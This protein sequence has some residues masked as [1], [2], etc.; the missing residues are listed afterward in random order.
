MFIASLLETLSIGI[1]IPLINFILDPNLDFGFI[2]VGF[3]NRFSDYDFFSLMIIA[4]FLIYLIK[5]LFL[6]FYAYFNASVL[7]NV[8]A[9]LKLK[10]F[11][12]Y[13]NKDFLYHLNNNST[14]FIRNIQNEVEVLMS[15]Y[16]S[17]FFD[18]F[19]IFYY[20]SFYIAISSLLLIFNINYNNHYFWHNR[21]IIKYF[22]KKTFK[23]IGQQRQFFAFSVLKN[24]RQSFML[25][26]EIKMLKKQN[27]FEDKLNHDNLKMAQ[28]GIKRT[29]FGALPRITFEFL[30]ISI[31]LI[32]LFYVNQEN[33]SLEKF[34]SLL[35]IYAI[36][37]FKIMP[38][39]NNLTV[40]YQKVKF[41]SPSLSTIVN[42]FTKNKIEDRLLVEENNEK[43]LFQNKIEIKD[44]SFSYLS[45]SKAIL[46]NI[47]LSIPKGS[48]IGIV[49]EN[50]SGKSTL[51]NLIC[52]LLEPVSGNIII[53]GKPVKKFRNLQSIIG[54]IPQQIYLIDED[55]KS[56]IALGQKK[57]NIDFKKIQDLLNLIDLDIDLNPD[58]IVGEDGKNISGGQK[59][60]IA[61]A[62]ALYSDPEILILDEAT[63]AMDL[64]SEQKFIDAVSNKN[65]NKSII[66]V[67]HRVKALK[68]CDI[69][70]KI[71]NNTVS[72]INK[73]SI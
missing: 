68:N 3:F 69:I 53:D 39:L 34:L 54:Y 55:I 8:S 6:I 73:N 7:L 27:F 64:N 2:H 71:E 41:G 31:A 14:L 24:L 38:S 67:S 62:R 19:I 48:S 5:Y 60:K 1:L 46:K 9:S 59:Q 45:D 21:N 43:I 36:A 51:I 35:A 20:N 17:P 32:S 28:L 52:G 26:K 16:V 47:N 66:I 18:I 23:E 15:N 63:S 56:N 44:L 49:G 25:I 13:L 33:I 42:L 12:H 29:V 58:Y 22:G 37:A 61:I 70:Y 72:E 57:E 40:S 50:G 30:F 4:I 65:L 10:I 11:K